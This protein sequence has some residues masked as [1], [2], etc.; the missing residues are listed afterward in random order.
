MNRRCF[1]LNLISLWSSFFHIGV[2]C[3]KKFHGQRQNLKML[4]DAYLYYLNVNNY[5]DQTQDS[6]EW[7]VI[8]FYKGGLIYLREE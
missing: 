4:I 2:F 1:F 8:Q 5:Y 3:S 7:Y 6:F